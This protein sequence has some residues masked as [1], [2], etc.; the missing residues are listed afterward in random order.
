MNDLQRK[1]QQ[2]AEDQ[3]KTLADNERRMNEE[4]AKAKQQAN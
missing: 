1:M 2:Q 4:I 3:K